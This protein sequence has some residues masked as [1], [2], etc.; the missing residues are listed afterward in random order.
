MRWTLIELVAGEGQTSDSLAGIPTPS[1]AAGGCARLLFSLPSLP[2]SM[3]RLYLIN[4]NQRRVQLSDE[5][6]LW[7]TR[8]TPSILPCRLGFSE[9]K[10][11]LIYQSP[12]WLL[13][14]GGLR[15]MDLTNLDKLCIDTLCAKWQ[16]DD[17]RLTE[18]IRRKEWYQWDRIQVVL[19]QG[20]KLERRDG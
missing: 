2:P 10:L 14:E 17:S 5:A 11:T 20:H 7:R 12:R 13:K 15:K 19:E 6:L 9:Y 1:P 16:F 4:H 3:N 18:V 8:V